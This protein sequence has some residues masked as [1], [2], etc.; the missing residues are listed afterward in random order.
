VL[1]LIGFLGLSADAI[2]NGGMIQKAV[3]L[4]R[5]ELATDNDKKN[6]FSPVRNPEG[7]NF[8]HLANFRDYSVF[9]KLTPDDMIATL[10]YIPEN[11]LDKVRVKSEKIITKDI[12]NLKDSFNKENFTSAEVD[13]LKNRYK[14]LQNF[15][16]VADY[17][18]WDSDI[19]P[20]LKSINNMLYN[21]LKSKGIDVDYKDIVRI[22]RKLE[23]EKIGS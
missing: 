13:E 5:Y 8:Y 6:M 4:F 20:T 10:K 14:A 16:I 18:G 21:V 22:K 19:L 23:S 1:H 12:L 11:E 3:D 2:F 7:T 17:M 9:Y 15:L